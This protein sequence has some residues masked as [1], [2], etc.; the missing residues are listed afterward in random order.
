MIRIAV[1]GSSLWAWAT[2]QKLLTLPGLFRV[3][4]LCDSR[5]VSPDVQAACQAHAIPLYEGLESMLEGR[6][7]ELDAV[8]LATPIHTH[9]PL[10]A[11]CLR[12]G[13][14][15]LLEKPP[16]ATI[17]ELDELEACQRLSGRRV[18]VC[19][20]WL[21]SDL[22]L[23]LRERL[24]TGQYGVVRRIRMLAGWPRPLEYYRRAGW[25]GR[26]RLGGD[27][28]LDGTI[29]N[30]LAHLLSLGLLFASD[31]ED[32]LALPTQV[33][34]EL[35]RTDTI[36]SENTASLRATTVQGIDLVMNASLCT[37]EFIDARLVLETDRGA[38][39]TVVPPGRAMLRDAQGVVSQLRDDQDPS[40]R[41]LQNL[42]AAL[43][44]QTGF[45]IGL[46]ACRGFTLAVNGAFE[47]SG[48]IHPIPLSQIQNMERE[49]QVY[50]CVRGMDA[51]LN[52]A[53]TAGQ[54]LAE[55]GAEW[56]VRGAPFSLKG[57]QRFPVRFKHTATEDEAEALPRQGGV[58]R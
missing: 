37:C 51:L 11:E 18:V 28:V 53:H 22:I 1:V 23:A 20:Q 25:A 21:Y 40:T 50:P 10:A 4:G 32:E 46:Q 13:C 31:S 6:R 35:Y 39:L 5:P 49:S 27:W 24:A 30:P 42:H 57:Y 55:A 48:H 3:V 15:V 52:K 47:S 44:A 8:Y 56:G 26:L 2:T 7:G 33:Q 36:E 9:L 41:M 45:E 29:N 58:E 17:Q 16:V 54:T 38:T 19:F 34:A 14:D 12:A 43:S